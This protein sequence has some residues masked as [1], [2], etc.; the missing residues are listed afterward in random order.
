MIAQ[1]QRSSSITG[2][3]VVLAVALL[4][5]QLHAGGAP[6]RA[7]AGD[8]T[9]LIVGSV[10]GLAMVAIVLARLF[11][12]SIGLIHS[13]RAAVGALIFMLAVKVALARVFLAP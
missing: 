9:L 1:L 10:L 7:L 11:G 6:E 12:R 4:G 13:D 5:S 3:A 2:K 8:L